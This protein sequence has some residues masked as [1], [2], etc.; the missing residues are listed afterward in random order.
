[1]H[2]LR[3]VDFSF[4]LGVH[5]QKRGSVKLLKSGNKHDLQV[6]DC[7]HVE[8]PQVV[9]CNTPIKEKLSVDALEKSRTVWSLLFRQLSKLLSR[10]GT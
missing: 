7:K 6:F 10:R 4:E 8:M 3:H 5:R 1:M 2:R 9:L